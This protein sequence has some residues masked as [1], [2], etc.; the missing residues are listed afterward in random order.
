MNRVYRIRRDGE[1]YNV[2]DQ[3]DT[4]VC[5][6]IEMD[7]YPGK[8]KWIPVWWDRDLV[9]E[10]P[11]TEKTTDNPPEGRWY[12]CGF[13]GEPCQDDELHW[14]DQWEAYCC[15]CCNVV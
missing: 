2:I 11:L 14:N 13:C 15:K 10:I 1:E 4:D 8:K 12:L 6:E 9:E 7:Y 3:T 5:V